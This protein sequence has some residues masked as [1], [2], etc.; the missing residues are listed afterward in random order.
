MF[1]ES[2]PGHHLQFT[3]AARLQAIPRFRRHVYVH[4][5]SEGWGLYSERLADDMGLYST[6]L[7]RLGML[8]ADSMRACRMV[9]DT[10]MHALGWSRDQAIAFM[11]DNSPLRPGIVIPEID[12]YIIDPG[13]SPSYMVGRLEIQRIRREAEHRQGEGFDLR[14]FHTAVLAGGSVPLGI[15]ER[16]I[17][18]RFPTPD[19]SD[20]PPKGTP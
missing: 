20:T 12:R 8:A 17:R 2:I 3:V 1:H 11:L 16:S 18:S 13:Q 6:P 15:L 10:G 14:A 19:S 5:Y 7:D 9:V 4:S